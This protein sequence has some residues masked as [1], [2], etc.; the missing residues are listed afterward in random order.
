MPDTVGW[1]CVRLSGVVF[2]AGGAYCAPIF[3]IKK[4]HTQRVVTLLLNGYTFKME[5]HRHGPSIV[6]APMVLTKPNHHKMAQTQ[7]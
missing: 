1:V 4:Y 3:L 2:Q 6:H 7:T 5:G